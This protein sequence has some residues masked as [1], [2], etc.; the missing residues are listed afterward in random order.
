MAET[1]FFTDPLRQAATVGHALRDEHFFEQCEVW[2]ADLSWFNLNA[3]LQ[4]IWKALCDFR[5]RYR[6]HP[7]I[8]EIKALHEGLGMDLKEQERLKREVDISLQ[9]AA[10]I[11]SDVLVPVLRDAARRELIKREIETNIG[12]K[13][14]ANDF[15]AC[16]L[17][18]SSLSLKLERMEHIG[19]TTNQFIPSSERNVG[20]LEKRREK[21]KG[22]VPF[23]ITY[24]DDALVGISPGDVVLISA[25]SG[26][27]KTQLTTS[28]AR[29]AVQLGLRVAYF[30]LE[31]AEDDIERR[32]KYNAIARAYVASG[33]DYRKI[34]YT[35]WIK[36]KLDH[37]LGPYER[38]GDIVL[39]EMS[40]LQTLY[41]SH[42]DF[43]VE[44]LEREM[45]RV[46]PEVDLIVVDH[47]HYIDTGDD[48][49]NENIAMKKIAQKV[50]EIAR[51]QKKA[52]LMVAHLNKYDAGGL[53]PTL[54]NIMGSSDLY[55]VATHAVILSR[56]EGLEW[57]EDVTPDDK[58]GCSGTPTFMCIRKARDAGLNRGTAITFFNSTSGTYQKRY[59]IGGLANS[60]KTWM[61]WDSIPFW[62][63][64]GT[65]RKIKPIAKGR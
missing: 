52:V 37:I 9:Q 36:G 64:F 15:E 31:E 48:A 57:D 44:S 2:E 3:H 19:T 51:Q 39:K 26:T 61:L 45:V 41:R 10:S 16:A 55:K 11:G 20:E 4:I 53:V 54:A 17:G 50:A 59:A 32:M 29:S 27:G 7:T 34:D 22:I 28:V 5:K 33:G 58:S 18:I 40:G 46:A 13:F 49:K 65:V 42:G 23:G 14:R 30:S 63:K 6:R 1:T 24:L 62:A 56:A 35:Y 25:S 43:D 21:Q 38:A 8:G 60:D 12:A 47:V